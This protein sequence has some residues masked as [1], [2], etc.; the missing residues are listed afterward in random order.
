MLTV[1]IVLLVVYQRHAAAVVCEQALPWKQP[2]CLAP[3]QSTSHADGFLCHF[4]VCCQSHSSAKPFTLEYN[5]TISI[6]SLYMPLTAAAAKLTHARLAG[7]LHAG[8]GRS[9]E[10]VTGLPQELK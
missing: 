9:S 7:L 6:Y 5:E 8:V 2:Q 10:P 3:Q 1:V 4:T